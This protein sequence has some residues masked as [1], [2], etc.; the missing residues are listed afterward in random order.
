MNNSAISQAVKY[1]IHDS[2]DDS[3][4]R[5]VWRFVWDSVTTPARVSIYESIWIV[6]GNSVKVSI[7]DAASGAVRDYAASGAA[8]DYFKQNSNE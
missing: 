5:L 7:R 3:V 1:S 4:R 6:I 2:I 8:R